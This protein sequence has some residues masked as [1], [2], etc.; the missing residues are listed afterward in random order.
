L[1]GVDEL[2]E[3]GSAIPPCDLR[4]PLACL[5]GLLGVRIETAATGVPYLHPRRELRSEIVSL[6]RQGPVDALRVGLVWQGNPEQRRDV[7][8]SCPLEKLIP[9]FR[10]PA[11][12]FFSLQ[13]GDRGRCQIAELQLGERIIDAG[14]ALTDFTETAAVAAALDLVITVDTATA[15]LAGAL[16][17]P[18]WTMLCHTPDWRW[19]LE[20]ADSPWYPTMRLFRQPKWGDWDSVVRQIQT[21]LLR[22]HS[23]TKRFVG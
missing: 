10:T 5:P 11:T 2:F 15:H 6:L 22:R 9:L 1:P 19:H 21:A 20:R 17:R 3:I 13:T 7:I 14:K 16:G 18:V 8:R 12:I 23:T 4:I